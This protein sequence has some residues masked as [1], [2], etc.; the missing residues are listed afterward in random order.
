MHGK[1]GEINL[2][3]TYAGKEITNDT[4]HLRIWEGH[5][6][7]EPS[8]YGSDYNQDE[9]YPLCFAPDKKVSA[10]DVA[11]VLCDRY[12]GTKYFPDETGRN[13]TRAIGTDETLSA[14]IIQVFP[15]LPADMACVSWISSGPPV[16]GVF[17]PV[18]NDCI[19][20]SDAYGANQPANDTGV[21]DTDHYPYYVFNDLCDY[22]MGQD[23]YKNYG[24]PV[25]AYWDES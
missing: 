9:T 20:V 18:S 16:Y 22:C 13:D 14:H 7:L 2:F 11:H 5:R 8:K 6:L 19:N 3:E 12:E 21:F 10:Q 15:N 24:K 4:A 25:Q 17:V 23:N 1:N